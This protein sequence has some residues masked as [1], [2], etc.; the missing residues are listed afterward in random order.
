MSDT[1]TI[2]AANNWYCCA[3]E[4]ND[5]NS[6]M[7]N[8]TY[9]YLESIKS[10]SHLAELDFNFADE[11]KK[12][13]VIN[14]ALSPNSDIDIDSIM[15]RLLDVTRL[16]LDYEVSETQKSDARYIIS[17]PPKTLKNLVIYRSN[18]IITNLETTCI[19]DY[20]FDNFALCA[21]IPNFPDTLTTICI[22]AK[23]IDETIYKLPASINKIILNVIFMNLPISHL[24]INLKELY[25]YVGYLKIDN[26]T[27]KHISPSIYM[28][29]HNLE[30]FELHCPKYD[31]YLDLPPNLI[32]FEFFTKSEYLHSLDGISDTIEKLCLY[33]SSYPHINKLPANC[34]ILIYLKCNDTMKQA[35]QDRFPNVIVTN[36]RPIN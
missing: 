13:I 7:E 15:D 36:R 8:L 32:E 28:L 26:T 20:T 3:S 1:N 14:G 2:T 34:K 25:I 17:R 29:P 11:Y 5:D 12:N 21:Y 35:L 4:N 24:P 23:T 27:N 30:I 10:K 19:I 31:Y 16:S 33:H 18:I 22:Q 9:I 6:I